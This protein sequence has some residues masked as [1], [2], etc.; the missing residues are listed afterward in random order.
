MGGLHGNR[1]STSGTCGASSPGRQREDG[2]KL[3]STAPLPLSSNAAAH[4]PRNVNEHSSIVGVKELEKWSGDPA[5]IPGPEK[6]QQGRELRTE[7]AWKNC[8]PSH[9]SSPTRSP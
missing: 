2:W 7:Q 6:Y 9:S 3:T 5:D 4:P 1:G 8:N